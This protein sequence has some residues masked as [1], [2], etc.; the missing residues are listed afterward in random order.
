M[1][2]GHKLKEKPA[3]LTNSDFCNTIIEETNAPHIRSN[4]QDLPVICQLFVQFNVAFVLFCRIYSDK[5]CFLL[6]QHE[7]TQSI[8]KGFA[9]VQTLFAVIVCP[10]AGGISGRGRVNC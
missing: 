5:Q 9:V 6:H 10:L 3:C 2:M 8:R 4:I 7:S 1:Q